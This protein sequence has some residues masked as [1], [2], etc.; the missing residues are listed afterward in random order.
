VVYPNGIIDEALSDPAMSVCRHSAQPQTTW[1]IP[2]P[3]E[4]RSRTRN[5]KFGIPVAVFPE[6]DVGT[7]QTWRITKNL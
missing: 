6:Y 1:F 2:L 3:E 4:C 7:E 5:W